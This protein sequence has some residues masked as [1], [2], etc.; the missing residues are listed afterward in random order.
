M[1]AAHRWVDTAARFDEVVSALDGEPAIALDTEFHRERTYYPQVALVQL[2]WGDPAAPD[3]VL[4]D[5]LAVDLA[6]LAPVLAGPTTVVMHAAQQ[7]LEVL[8]RTC[9]TLPSRLFDTQLAAGFAGHNMPSLAN[10]V[11]A[12]LGR[13]LPKGDR[14]ADWLHRPLTDDERSYAAS[15]VVHLLDLHDRLRTDLDGGGRL[16][17]A[18]DECAELLARAQNARD[19]D[20]AW[21]KVKEARQLRGEAVG[22]A[23]ALAAWR[24]RRAAEVDQPVRFV[25]PDLALV[26]IAQRPPAGADALRRVRGLDGRHLRDGAVDG[27]LGA[28]QAGRELPRSRLRLPPASDV[29][30]E[31]RPAVALVSA[32]VSQLGRE[33]RI[34]PALLATRG[35]LEAFLRKD[36]SGRLWSGWR[37]DVVGDAVQRLV[38]G[39]AALAFDGRGGLVL[40]ARSR[41]PVPQPAG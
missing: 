4:V 24:E 3:I 41:L 22:V 30:R 15:D 37:H 26:S 2:A 32:W 18:E 23:Q 17:W 28:V 31:L 12:L 25:L 34:D 13:R 6:P 10:L 33:L 9:A 29:E 20:E 35:D 5:T 38:G 7:D 40:E 27:I 39:E 1:T 8:L 21:W 16:G 11:Q 19:P 14:L 36:M